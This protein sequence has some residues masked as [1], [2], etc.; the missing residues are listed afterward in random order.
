MLAFNFKTPFDSVTTSPSP[1]SFS[2][3]VHLAAVM[4]YRKDY[5][6]DAVVERREQKGRRAMWVPEDTILNISSC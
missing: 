3:F 4:M 2:S 1:L 5:K 6:M